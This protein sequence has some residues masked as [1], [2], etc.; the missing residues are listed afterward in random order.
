MDLVNNGDVLVETFGRWPSFHD[1][2]LVSLLLTREHENIV[3]LEAKIHVFETTPT[4]GSSG[5]YV[6]RNHVL[7]TFKFSG[8]REDISIRWFNHQ[9]VIA[10]L[11]INRQQSAEPLVQ[12][13]IPSL[14]GADVS[15]TCD[16]VEVTSVVPYASTP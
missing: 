12:V 7:V 11:H 13:E 3:S 4:V 5:A 2:E 10:A 8:V 1:A 14:Y 16:A 15:F 9:N 6:S